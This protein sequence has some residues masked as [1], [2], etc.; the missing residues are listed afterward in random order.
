VGVRG[1]DP[2]TKEYGAPFAFTGGRIKVV[3]INIGE[4]VYVDRERDFHAAMSRD[5]RGASRPGC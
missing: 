2:V 4:D 3:E 5:R 1:A